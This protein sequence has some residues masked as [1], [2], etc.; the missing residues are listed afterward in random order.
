M[1]RHENLQHGENDPG[2]IKMRY[3]QY[4]NFMLYEFNAARLGTRH[5]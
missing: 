5:F 1:I 3:R 2:K 4:S